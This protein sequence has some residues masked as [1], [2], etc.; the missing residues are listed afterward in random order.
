MNRLGERLRGLDPRLVDYSLAGALALGCLIEAL[1]FA[2]EDT[3]RVLIAVAG[4]ISVASVALRRKHPLVPP[5]ALLAADLVAALVAPYYLNRL[6]APY[7]AIMVSQYSLG[8]YLPGRV[9]APLAFAVAF[10]GVLQIAQP[11]EDPFELFWYFLVIGIPYLVGRTLAQRTRLQAELRKRTRQLEHDRK[12][13]AERAVERERAKLATE[14]QAVVANG[15]S[16][17]V[18]QAEGVPRVIAAGQ[19]DRA[20]HALTVIEETGRDA[21]AEMRRLLGV[22]RRDGEGA[23]LAPQPTLAEAERLAERLRAEG[24]AIELEIEGERVEL[25][26]GADL[27]AYRILQEAL[28]SALRA[29]AAG[30]VAVI[31]YDRGELRIE[32]EDDRHDPRPDPVPLA[33]MRERLGLYGGRVRT[34]TGA[35]GRRFR[36]AAR[37]PL[38]EAS[39]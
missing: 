26:T 20:A 24:L 4:S 15:V 36:V 9:W 34:G 7:L 1:I 12:L 11:L 31:G 22:L 14:L 27:T 19:A 28:E 21:L 10:V 13:R 35:G 17:M 38:Q 33:A 25:R 18:V 5:V 3:R 29:G 2:N 23:T 32:V 39:Q 30:A 16:A 8:R 6:A 37:L